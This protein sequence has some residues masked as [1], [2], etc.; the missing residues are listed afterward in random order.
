MIGPRL[1]DGPA[2][3]EDYLSVTRAAELTPGGVP[4]SCIVRWI[5]RGVWA[6][7]GAARRR[8][9]LAASK[10]GGRWRV[11]AADLSSFIEA[12]T[13]GALGIQPTAGPSPRRTGPVLRRRRIERALAACRAM[14]VQI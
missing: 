8:V 7:H 5:K 13:D 3:R 6:G 9:F 2:A 10:C 4:P 11:R 12:T 14:G 1:Q